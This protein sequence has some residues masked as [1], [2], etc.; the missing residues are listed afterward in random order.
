MNF[1]KKQP[2]RKF[3]VGNSKKFYI[4]DCGEMH[5]ENDEQISFK[6][7]SGAEYDVA[8]K[9]WGFY[10]TPSLNGRLLSFGLNAVLVVNTLICRY[11]IL[12]VEDG[13]EDD[14]FEYCRD[15]SLEVL[16]WLNSDE[17]LKGLGCND[18]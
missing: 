2:P 7:E 13:K 1:I 10:A 18:D 14:F 5:L 11:Y 9:S 8:R 12:L 3:V 6:T 15:E 4:S 17:R 16:C